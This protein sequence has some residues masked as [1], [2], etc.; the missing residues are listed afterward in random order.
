M[1]PSCMM[2]NYT[3]EAVLRV[4]LEC[5]SL[6]RCDKKLVEGQFIDRLLKNKPGLSQIYHDGNFHIML[7]FT[8]PG[9]LDLHKLKGRPKRLVD[10]RMR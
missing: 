8:G 4:S 7:N 2:A 9:G 10:R 6:D 1:K 5:F 3:G